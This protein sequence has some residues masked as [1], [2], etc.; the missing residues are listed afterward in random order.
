MCRTTYSID[1]PIRRVEATYRA[2]T[3]VELMVV[4]V[5]VAML[6][7]LTFAGLSGVRDRAK[8]D[9]T[10]ST[11]RKLHE[12]VIP[13][14]E[15]YQT[16]RMRTFGSTPTMVWSTS[17]SRFVDQP[18]VSITSSANAATNRLWGLRT[19]QALEMPDQWADV[20]PVSGSPI[21]VPKW[22]VTAPV[23]RYGTVK[24]SLSGAATPEYESAECLAMIVMRGGV[25][26]G[27][28]ESFRA[29]ELGDVDADQRPEI[30]D[31]WGK[32]I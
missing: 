8:A 30:L 31:G 2:F 10:R 25:D 9:K 17:I 14:F 15:S 18:M 3:L 16:R 26:A 6:A 20:A 11:I 27:L 23:K 28:A 24:W 21:A 32:R 12:I 29:D 19:L 5:I 22:A 4:L 13:H 1:V 7:A